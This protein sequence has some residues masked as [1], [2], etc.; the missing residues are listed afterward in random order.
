MYSWGS[1][2]NGELGLGG[3]E[4]TNV[5]LP[6]SLTFN[7]TQV[8]SMSAGGRHSLML[9]E[10]GELYS[11][12]SNDFGQLGR[13]GSQ[14]RLQQIT[15]LAE[16]TVK[17]ISAGA[18]HS[19]AVDMWGSVFS[20]GSDEY[21]QL[22]HNQG[23]QSLRVPRLLKSLGTIKVSM[24]SA[25][26]YHS[27]ALTASGQLYT[28]GSNSKG[29]LGLG[30]SI[31]SAFTPT[32]VDTLPGVPLASVVCG[33]NHTLVCTVSGA[34]FAFGSNNHGQLGLGDNEDRDLPT[35]VP[36]EVMW[37][38]GENADGIS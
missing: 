16:Y 9:S 15:G 37:I 23:A 5:T 25:G 33:G 14:T 4:D 12:G 3:L 8:E 18:N 36:T 21:G 6:T 2:S 27:A 34:V 24:V 28:W 22:G 35:Q 13:E 26:M 31:N 17:G 7:Q 30:K 38:R 10:G 29:Q 20:W 32:L 19:L 11:C 1:A